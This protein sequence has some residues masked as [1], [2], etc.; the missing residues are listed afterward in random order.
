MERCAQ[1][2]GVQN[3]RTNSHAGFD[4]HNPVLS[5]SSAR[6]P[7]EE[8]GNAGPRHSLLTVEAPSSPS[9]GSRLRSS[10][11]DSW[12]RLVQGP[13]GVAPTWSG[14]PAPA[15]SPLPGP[16]QVHNRPPGPFATLGNTVCMGLA[17][18][19]VFVFVSVFVKRTV[20]CVGQY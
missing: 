4:S 10:T 2:G 17:H 14:S 9:V 7:G 20:A 13:P 18:L 19:R 11:P 1:S 5:C 8:T 6:R 16:T 12:V 3:A 15:S